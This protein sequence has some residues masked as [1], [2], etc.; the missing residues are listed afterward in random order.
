VDLQ[1]PR[2]FEKSVDRWI[3]TPH[4][5]TFVRNTQD[6]H[7][8]IAKGPI[9]ESLPSEIPSAG[10]NEVIAG[11]P[12]LPPYIAEHTAMCDDDPDLC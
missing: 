2:H 8:Y 3:E 11:S 4:T 7:E 9:R 12:S 1:G 5:Q 10:F 6:G